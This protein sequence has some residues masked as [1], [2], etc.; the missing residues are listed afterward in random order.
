MSYEGFKTR[1]KQLNAK[2]NTANFREIKQSLIELQNEVGV[3]E[4]VAMHRAE[5]RDKMQEL[6][7]R[8]KEYQE[9]DQKQFEEEAGQN[10]EFIKQKLVEAIEYTE[11]NLED[12]NG[13]WQKLLEVQQ[14]F[15]GKKLIAD[16]REHLHNTLQKLFQLARKR[17]EDALRHSQEVSKGQMEKLDDVVDI[18]VSQCE[19]A[20]I[21][22]AWAMLLETKD[23]VLNAQLL[24]DHRKRLV[25]KLQ[26]GFEIVKLRREE[27]Q[28]D[29]LKNA[30]DNA[31][32]IDAML[33]DADQAID[34]NI[35]F[36]EKWN[37]LLAIQKEFSN[38]K[39]EKSARQKLYNKLQKL[40]QILKNEQGKDQQEFEK[41]AQENLN[42][43]KPLVDKA[44]E[45][46]NSTLEFRKTKG[47]LIKVQSEFKGRKM[48][49]M[50]REKLYSRLQAAFD[51]LQK[52]LDEYIASRK[53]AREFRVVGRLSEVNM[54][55]D[56]L[57]KSIESDREKLDL[58]QS[59]MQD[60]QT[61]D[62]HTTGKDDLVNQVQIMQAA[63]NRKLS[64]WEI[65]ST[66]KEKLL[67]NK[68]K[69]DDLD[70]ED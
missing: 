55:I 46:A 7:E 40:F 26:D 41:V 28:N 60:S 36:K 70:P 44:M 8:I 69:L 56:Q 63:I 59:A 21:E 50:E 53:E 4:L 9:K 57:E 43:L 1:V 33:K 48:R 65:L 25:D 3:F 6:F 5:L 34:S 31:D 49:A 13:V 62:A 29:F 67:H 51:V 68:Q 20:D 10:F 58:L 14:H 30:A 11:A 23:K 54:K 42:Y 38:R 12:H 37:L 22:K 52:R 61:L 45:L 19:T 39:L 18:V 15:K 27:R 17:R 2:L 24:A 35:A 66:E 64:E 47:F 32:I 16:Q